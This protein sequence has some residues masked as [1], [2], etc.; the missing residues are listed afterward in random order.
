ML[1]DLSK[2]DDYLPHNLF[3]AK[4]QSYGFSEVSVELLLSYLANGV[5]I[6]Q[7]G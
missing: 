4:S 7:I 1:M 5:Q 6:I 2:A 3:L